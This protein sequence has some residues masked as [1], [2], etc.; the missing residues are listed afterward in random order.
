MKEPS[1]SKEQGNQ[2]PR[3]VP[4]P[5]ERRSEDTDHE[6][7]T[8]PTNILLKPVHPAKD[9]FSNP[10]SPEFDSS[11]YSSV[12]CNIRENLLHHLDGKLQSSSSSSTVTS[13][14]SCS[15]AI[16]A[17]PQQQQQQPQ[18][19]FYEHNVSQIQ[20]PIDISLTAATPVYSK[21]YGNEE[22]EN[23]SEYAQK[24]GKSN[25]SHPRRVSFEK[26]N[27]PR[28]Y[29]GKEQWTCSIKDLSKFDISTQLSLRKKQQLL[30]EHLSLSRLQQITVLAA[31]EMAQNEQCLNSRDLEEAGVE[32]DKPLDVEQILVASEGKRDC[33]EANAKQLQETEFTVEFGNFLRLRKWDETTTSEAAKK[34]ETVYAELTGEWSRPRI[35]VCGTC[36]SKHVSSTITMSEKKKMVTLKQRTEHTRSPDTK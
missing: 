13:S 14:T 27:F 30:K 17:K 21:E 3:D 28:K 20:F 1:P 24:P 8:E 9:N 34:Q 15:S 18:Q 23:N 35:Y 5:K 10:G 11:F 25:R 33:T 19:S 22:Y 31:S 6:H 16:D 32:V 4:N 29:D 36:A 7:R 2:S 12:S 26:Y